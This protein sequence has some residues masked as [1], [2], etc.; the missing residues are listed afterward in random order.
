MPFVKMHGRGNDFVMARSSDLDWIFDKNGNSSSDPR[1]TSTLLS[2]LAKSVCDRRFG[3]GADGLIIRLDAPAHKHCALTIDYPDLDFCEETWIYINSD[4]IYSAMCGNG[5]RCFAGFCIMDGQEARSFKVATACGPV[6]VE[7]RGVGDNEPDSSI[8]DV[9]I[10]LEAPATC[11]QVSLD[12]FA[13]LSNQSLATI[14]RIFADGKATGHLIDLGNPHYVLFLPGAVFADYWMSVKDIVDERGNVLAGSKDFPA[15]FPADLHSLALDL[16]KDETI[17]PSG[18]NIEF[19]AVETGLSDCVRMLVVER[20]CGPTLACASG[21]CAVVVGGIKQGI[22]NRSSRVILPGGLLDV[23]WSRDDGPVELRGWAQ[24]VAQGVFCIYP[25]ADRS[26]VSGGSLSS[27][28]SNHD[29]C[30]AIS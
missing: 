25:G 24:V 8:Y 20:G 1:Q 11:R 5:L 18:A 7:A 9:L 29:F 15:C 12:Q 3:L 26:V 30:E 16:A 10:K 27:F 19:A 14:A 4:G 22:L 6:E 23:S 28:D 13:Q 21:A 17:F 2:T